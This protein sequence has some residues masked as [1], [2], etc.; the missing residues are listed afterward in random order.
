MSGF[1]GLSMGSTPFTYEK[2]EKVIDK[3]NL[4]II[5]NI[6][7]FIKK[8]NI[9]NNFLTIVKLSFLYSIV[10]FVFSFMLPFKISSLKKSSHRF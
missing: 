3:E 5:L 9:Y 1:K 4:Y 7:N 8:L 6:Y 2:N 10:T